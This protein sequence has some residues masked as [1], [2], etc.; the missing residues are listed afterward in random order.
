MGVIENIKLVVPPLSEQ[1]QI[2]QYLNEKTMIIDKLISTKEKKTDLLKQQRISLINQVITKGLN[3]KVQMKDSGLEWVG[4]IPK[5]WKISKL[6]YVSKLNGSNVDKHIYEDE[7]Q[8]L[9]CNY[10]DVYYNEYLDE[11]INF[12]NGSCTN[13]EYH[14]FKLKLGDVLL[15]KDSE[16]PNDIGIPSYVCKDFDNVICGYHLT[17]ITPMKNRVN[18]HFLFRQLQTKRVKSYFE[19]NSNGITRYGLGKSSI[20]NLEIIEPPLSEQ[21]Q[22]VEYILLHT[23]EIDELVSMEQKKIDLLKEYRQSFISEVITGKIDVRT[24]VN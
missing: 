8:I 6:K 17:M 1:I 15:T 10:T 14:K 16:T 2:I 20:E 12:N 7:K 5:H 11:K 4:E 23:K 22:I 9:L 13:D 19:V 21:K 24:N 3:P 18:G